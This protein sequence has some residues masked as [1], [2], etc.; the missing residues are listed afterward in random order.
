MKQ[1]KTKLE[2]NP[3]DNLILTREEKEIEK[4][5]GKGEFKKNPNFKK[6]KKMYQEMAK[7]TLALRKSKRVTFRVNQEDLI[8][9]KTKAKKND[10]PYQT[11]LTVLIR[12]YVE[13][14]V[15]MNI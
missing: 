4:A 8:K 7:N 6:E 11:L 12:Q 5:L 3:F 15:N 2:H 10:M 13:G 9:L 1:T 14:N